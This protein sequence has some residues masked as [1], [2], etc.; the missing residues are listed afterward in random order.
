MP[1]GS[2]SHRHMWYDFM[3][4]ASARSRS[5]MS[6]CRASMMSWPP[7]RMAPIA[8][9]PGLPA[10]LP[11]GRLHVVGTFE[12]AFAALASQA[13]LEA[14]SAQSKG[15]ASGF[16]LVSVHPLA[17]ATDLVA[18]QRSYSVAETNGTYVSEG[19][20]IVPFWMYA[21]MQ[22]T[23]S[24]KSPSDVFTSPLS[25]TVASSAE[26]DFYIADEVAHVEDTSL[27]RKHSDYFIKQIGKL[28]EIITALK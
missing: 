28:E 26:V 14:D 23:S 1:F 15:E 20:W 2:S 6:L 21:S 8:E 27:V 4:Y 5:W 7:K 24:S 18:A 17:G 9:A 16:R 12:G 13:A 22:Y 25:G 11:S 10:L 19:Q 3:Y